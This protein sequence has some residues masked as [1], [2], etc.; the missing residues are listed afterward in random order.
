MHIL[1]FLSEVF[2]ILFFTPWSS[3]SVYVCFVPFL[4]T[5]LN[6]NWWSKY[7]LLRLQFSLRC[8]CVCVCVCVHVLSHTVCP[9]LCDPRD[10]SPP[11]SS[12]HAVLQARTLEWVANSFS[13]GPSR[14]RDWTPVSCVS[15]LAGGCSSIVP[16]GDMLFSFFSYPTGLSPGQ[17]ISAPLTSPWA[18]SVHSQFP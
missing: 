4:I 8:V 12:A 6:D 1:K 7:Y 14:P 11:G 5:F 10:C 17:S 18:S 3:P 15:C 2:K 13:R 16:P 9:A